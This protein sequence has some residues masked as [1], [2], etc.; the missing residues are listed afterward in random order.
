MLR[1]VHLFDRTNPALEVGEDQTLRETCCSIAGATEVPFATGDAAADPRLEEHPAR[2][3]TLSYCGVPIRNAEGEPI[4][5]LCHLDLVPRD[6]P[7]ADIPVLER[8][9]ELIAERIRGA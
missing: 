6:V 3:A 9:A 1:N 8:A 2:E 4:G 7:D 5:T